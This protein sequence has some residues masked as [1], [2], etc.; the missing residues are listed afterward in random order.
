MQACYCMSLDSG[1]LWDRVPRVWERQQRNTDPCR[2]C[3]SCITTSL[4]KRSVSPLQ[5]FS[6]VCG[7]V[8]KQ[9]CREDMFNKAFWGSIGFPPAPTIPVF[10]PSQCLY[11]RNPVPTRSELAGCSD[12]F[13]VR[14]Q[15]DL[16][17]W[18]GF[19]W[20]VAK[21]EAGWF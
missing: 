16:L 6:V 1:S 3:C 5:S 4:Q 2:S 21:I 9:A 20:E 12:L 11:Q 7:Q 8:K 19:K 10:I 15:V 18:S 13:G 14:N 17:T